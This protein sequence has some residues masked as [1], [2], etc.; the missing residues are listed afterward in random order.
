MYIHPW[1]GK[2]MF[3]LFAIGFVVAILE[4]FFGVKI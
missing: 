2:I 3:G 4:T 1:Y